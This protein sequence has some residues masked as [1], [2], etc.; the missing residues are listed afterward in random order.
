ML[1]FVAT[2]LVAISLLPFFF[3]V[4]LLEVGVG[5]VPQ[6]LQGGLARQL[7]GVAGKKRL[8]RGGDGRVGVGVSTE[9]EVVDSNQGA[10][11]LHPSQLLDSV[12]L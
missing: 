9:T 1:L 3:L 6:L 12:N 8:L 5:R 2:L 10:L 4:R 7:L 11:E